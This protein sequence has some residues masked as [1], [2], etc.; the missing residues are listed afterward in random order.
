MRR[1][2]LLFLTGGLLAGPAFGSTYVVNP[3]GTGDFPTIQAAVD[4]AVNGDVIELGSGVFTGDGNRDVD[5]LGKAI[6]IRSQGG[7]GA[8]VIDCQGSAGEPHRGFYFFLLEGPDSVLGGVTITHGRSWGGAAVYCYGIH[9]SPTITRCVFVDNHSS[10]EGGALFADL[11]F[12]QVTDCVFTNN[13]ALYGGGASICNGA[14]A[15][16]F[17]TRCTFVG[18]QASFGGGLRI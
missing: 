8:C 16:A 17:L 13:S 2:I 14:S 9:C 10:G 12:P 1:I 18:N 11:A 7:P 15:A 5:Y 4:A 6:T 3:D